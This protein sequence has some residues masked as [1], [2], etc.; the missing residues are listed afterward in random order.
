MRNNNPLNI[1]YVKCNEWKGR[2]P[3]AEKKDKQFEEFTDILFGLRAAFKLLR[4]YIE[5]YQCD[6]VAKIISKWAPFNENR[7][8]VYI[9]VV[10]KRTG[11]KPDSVME[12]YDPFDVVPLVQAMIQVECGEYMPKAQIFLGYHLL[13]LQEGNKQPERSWDANEVYGEFAKEDWQHALKSLGYEV[14]SEKAQFNIIRMSDG[15]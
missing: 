4:T 2:V 5:K 6:T 1:R 12:F 9:D 8:D 14:K 7:T 13:I 3:E 15:S 11:F 10:C